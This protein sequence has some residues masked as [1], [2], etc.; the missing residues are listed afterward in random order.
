M[1]GSSA[2]RSNSSATGVTGL[3]RLIKKVERNLNAKIDRLRGE[4]E[5]RETALA[6]A[7][8]QALNEKQTAEGVSQLRL[9]LEAQ[10]KA[11][12]ID[13][14]GNRLRPLPA[15]GVDPASDVV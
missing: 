3:R 5:A 10:Y 15:E 7:R 4:L 13:G 6:A 11:G 14:K 1:K 12:I 8:L 9:D 2:R